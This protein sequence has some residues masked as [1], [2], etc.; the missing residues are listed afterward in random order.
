[1]MNYTEA[2]KILKRYLNIMI[3]NNSLPDGIEAMNTAIIVLGAIEQIRWERDLAIEQL[4]ELGGEL[5]EK[6]D[7]IKRH[8]ICNCCKSGQENIVGRRCQEC[9]EHNMFECISQ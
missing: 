5:G 7:L 8:I 9:I 1:M 2:K 4:H 3:E 6:T